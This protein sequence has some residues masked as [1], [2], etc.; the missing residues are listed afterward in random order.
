[1]V[2]DI[3]FEKRT[4]LL[5]ILICASLIMFAGAIDIIKSFAILYGVGIGASVQSVYSGS[6]L[7][8]SIERISINSSSFQIAIDIAYMLSIAATISLVSSLALFFKRGEIKISAV[9]IYGI[10][11][12]AFSLIYLSVL[13]LTLLDFYTYI[14]NIYVYFLIASSALG[15]ACSI[16]IQYQINRS[17]ESAP[18]R[19]I[20]IDPSSPFSSIVAL[21]DGV[22]SKLSGDL[23]IVD[24]HFNSISLI[25]FHRLI[26]DNSNI[27]SITI[28]TSGVMMDMDLAKNVFDLSNE[29][30]SKNVNLQFRVMSD[31]DSAIQH[32]RFMMDDNYA[33][34]IPPFNIINKKSEHINRINLSEVRGRF[35]QLYSNSMTIENY[36]A[37]M[38]KSD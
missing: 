35:R 27:T 3:E 14:A 29:M 1:M 32:E 21:R 7:V 10:L 15:I 38:A 5:I 2:S 22:F 25:N 12:I 13:G 36:R 23:K 9:R 16:Y 28:I 37:K 30:K 8:Q 17:R 34:K 24:K 6:S 26:S 33:Y 11:N 20:A 18:K 4:Y 19:S 31:S